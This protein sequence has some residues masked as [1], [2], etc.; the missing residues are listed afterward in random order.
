MNNKSKSN[1][2]RFIYRMKLIKK[3]IRAMANP[4]DLQAEKGV[5]DWRGKQ[6]D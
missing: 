3:R 6:I 4:S 2:G 5:L 1:K